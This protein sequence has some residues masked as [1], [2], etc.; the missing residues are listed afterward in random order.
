M[1]HAFL[2]PAQPWFV[3][4]ATGTHTGDVTVA[5]CQETKLHINELFLELVEP[6]G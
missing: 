2:A 5:T 3:T 1:N 6:R 4:W